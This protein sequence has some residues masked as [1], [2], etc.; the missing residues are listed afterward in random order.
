[1]DEQVILRLKIKR[2]EYLVFKIPHLHQIDEDHLT[3]LD[4]IIERENGSVVYVD[5][6]P[7]IGEL[8]ANP[9]LYAGLDELDDFQSSIILHFPRFATL[10]TIQDLQ[11]DLIQLGFFGGGN[12][13]NLEYIVTQQRTIFVV[14]LDTESG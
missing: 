6:R 12:I 2:A 9:D 14:E 11:Q 7:E 13:D 5:A 4:E 8:I 10:E 1:M 3:R